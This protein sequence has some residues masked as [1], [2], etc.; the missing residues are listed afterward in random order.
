VVDAG[1]LP[2]RPHAEPGLLAG[3]PLGAGPAP[4]AGASLPAGELPGAREVAPGGA[5]AQEEPP[6]PL[7]DGRADL[8][9]HR[10][11]DTI[12]A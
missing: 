7:D 4:L 9:S 3:L 6:V 1:D 10:P 5:A 2:A 12:P 8:D 11:D